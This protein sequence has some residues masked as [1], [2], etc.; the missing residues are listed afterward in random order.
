VGLLQLQRAAT[1]NISSWAAVEV[2][3]KAR[4]VVAGRVGFVQIQDSPL[5]LKPTQSPLGVV[6]TGLL[7]ILDQTALMA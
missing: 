7:R 3:V 6:V 2:V 5:L 4:V 1:W